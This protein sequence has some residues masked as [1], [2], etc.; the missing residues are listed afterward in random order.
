MTAMNPVVVI[1]LDACDP[2]I[3][4]RF[5]A[6]GHLP[7]LA[8]LF[9]RAARR[10][11][12]N[13]YGLFVGAL[14]RNFATGVGPDRH[15]FHCWDE[16]DIPSYARRLT[17]LPEAA[18]TTFWRRLS[19]AGRRVAVLDV[20]HSRADVPIDGV[21]VV[22]WGAHD[23]HFGFHT[24]PPNK[25]A[26]ID[27]AFGLHPVLGLDAYAAR[28]FAPDDYAHRAGPLRTIEEERVL[29]D[30]LLRGVKGKRALSSALLAEG[31]WDLFVDVFGEGH[32]TGHQLWHLHDPTHERYDPVAVKALGGDPILQLYRELDAALGE[33]LSLLG[34]GATVLVLLSH[35]MGPH[36]DGTHLL[37][38]VLTRLDIFNRDT[39]A[40]S[41]G[42]GVRTASPLRRP[43]Q[44][45]MTAFA[46]PA[47][48]RMARANLLRSCPEYATPEKRA[49]QAFFMEP[50]NTVYGGVRLNLAGR[51]P[52]G[53]VQP[54][55][56]DAVRRRLIDDLQTLVNLDTGSR[57]VRAVEP[58]ERWYR[59][60]PDDTMPDLF[61]DWEHGAPIESVWSPKTGF[62]HG[63]Y[64]N[65][66]SGD[67]KPDGL[68]LAYGPG[69]PTSA[70]L[71]GVAIEDLAPSIT[72]RLG[73]TLD[74]VD[75]RAFLS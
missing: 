19:C 42:P 71:P 25:A 40:V 70:E 9:E 62:V 61:V 10:P 59:R 63:R 2:A 47:M 1:G 46:V 34:D 68:L 50:N 37:D 65:W 23:R 38:E 44:E 29:L 20:P 58:A 33:I 67:H 17:T 53:C 72:A 75:G 74:D 41:R 32:A 30:G 49:R 24:W 11:L 18:E 13:P 16:I 36:H 6:E 15:R 64:T 5:A 60:S 3:A 7:S 51:E 8:R 31:K 48:H 54:D 55:E 28:E 56:V 69:I 21:Q 27:S 22:E 39:P 14:W 52:M 66:R 45:L 4:Q 57:A 12:R 43:L 26:E 35:G 73:L